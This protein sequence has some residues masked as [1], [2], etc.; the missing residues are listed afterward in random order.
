M[1]GGGALGPAGI[2][3]CAV[4]SVEVA[5]NS[6]ADNEMRRRIVSPDTKVGCAGKETVAHAVTIVHELRS[7][8]F[9]F[10]DK[11]DAALDREMVPDS[12]TFSQNRIRQSISAFATQSS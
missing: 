5:S 3:D 12:R 11:D 4:A 8:L 7:F 2:G 10:F 6:K 1:I 9:V